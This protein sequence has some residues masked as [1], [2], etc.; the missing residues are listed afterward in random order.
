MQ[1]KKMIIKNFC[2][3]LINLGFVKNQIGKVQGMIDWCGCD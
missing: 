3:F 1:I 2:G